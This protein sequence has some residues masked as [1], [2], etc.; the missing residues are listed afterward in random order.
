MR[1][2][3]Q[4]SFFEEE[5]DLYYMSQN[6]AARHLGVTGR[7]INYWET[8]G[9]LH[10]DYLRSSG[11]SR[12][13]TPGDMAELKFIKA[14]L[15]DQGYSIP[16]LKAKL[17]FLS[18]PYRYDPDDLFWDMPAQSWKSRRAIAA[19]EIEK[20]SGFLAERLADLFDEK[21]AG[22]ELAA[23]IVSALKRALE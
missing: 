4:L 2:N 12:R 23:L 10:P 3:R 16:S 6:D 5:E 13:Y 11:K 19:E 22:E 9:L 8:Q 18:A 1:K 20:N 14:M 7:M 21:E 15:V 17:A